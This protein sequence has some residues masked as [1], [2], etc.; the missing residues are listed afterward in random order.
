MINSIVNGSTASVVVCQL[1]LK[2]N[3]YKKHNRPLIFEWFVFC[4]FSIQD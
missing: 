1:Q 2:E 4:I 3:M